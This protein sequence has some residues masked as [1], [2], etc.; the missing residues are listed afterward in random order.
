MLSML[1]GLQPVAI[2][3]YL[4]GLPAMS[5][6]F[7]VP[8]AQ[9][10]FTLGSL[11]LSFG[12]SMLIW[13][14]LSDRFGRR[15]VLLWG[16]GLFVL[17]SLACTVAP[18]LGWMIAGRMAQGVALGA[19]IM[20]ARAV[21]RDCYAPAE[22]TR[23]MSK[24]LTGLGVVACVSAPLGGL[25]AL[26]HWRAT[27]AGVLV[28]GVLALAAIA[29]RFDETLHARRLDA[30]QPRQLVGTWLRILRHPRFLAFTLVAAASNTT[31]FTYLGTSSF[32]LIRM[33]G[34]DQLAY[35]LCI[36]SMSVCYVSGTMLCRH[37]LARTGLQRTMDLGAGL[38]LLSGLL[39]LA[40]FAA[41][42]DTVWAI[43]LPANLF[44]V[45]HGINQPCSQNGAIS[46]FPEAAGTASALNGFSMMMTSF[47]MGLWLGA[48]MD[49][50][51][52]PLVQGMAFWVTVIALGSW[53]VVRRFAPNPRTH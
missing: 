31:L 2:D 40:L 42:V 43:V 51:A 28:T 4:P 30:L 48:H 24:A 5:E 50:T 18:S 37:L 21:V 27:L 8:V 23:A 29:W 1:M 32:V 44:L 7:G 10:Q 3:M 52:W 12:V 22:G 11:L 19:A 46:P 36:A 49:G 33:H 17:S 35:G 6:D 16:L 34:L 20:T 14:P 26:L 38:S 13:G 45:A 15:P 9:V 39:L 53:A 47:L 41:G 25:L